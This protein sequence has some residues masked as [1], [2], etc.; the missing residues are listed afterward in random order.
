MSCATLSAPEL[1]FPYVELALGI[2]LKN[3]SLAAQEIHVQPVGVLE[4]SHKRIISFAAALASCG[5]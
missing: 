3:G 1:A 4:A 5:F 2:T